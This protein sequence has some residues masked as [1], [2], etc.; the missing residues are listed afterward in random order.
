VA[1]PGW[2]CAWPARIGGAVLAAVLGLAWSCAAASTPTDYQVKAV[3]LFNFAQFVEWP[4]AAFTN[5]TSPIIIG[6]LGED[7]FGSILDETVKGE[8]VRGR[9]IVVKRLALEDDPK[10][11]HIL[12]ISRSEKDR[13]NALLEGLKHAPVLTVGE[14][15]TFCERGGMINFVRQDQNIRLEA[16]RAGAEDAGLKISSRLLT[17]ARLVK[18]EP[19]KARTQP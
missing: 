8:A 12:F 14:V 7:P 2:N 4:S 6:I 13:V 18:T 3:F 1:R 9:H 5:E 10:A 16:N 17:L 15:D 11:C 19:S